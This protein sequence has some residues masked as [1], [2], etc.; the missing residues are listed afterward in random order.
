MLSGVAD[1]GRR[2]AIWQLRATR[3]QLDERHERDGRDEPD[4]HGGGHDAQ[5]RTY[6]QQHDARR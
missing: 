4:G 2:S 1:A 6:A 3:S 5:Q